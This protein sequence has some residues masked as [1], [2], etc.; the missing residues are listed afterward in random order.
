LEL[1]SDTKGKRRIDFWLSVGV[2]IVV[3]LIWI[4]FA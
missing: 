1:Q 3:A 2:G 4:Y